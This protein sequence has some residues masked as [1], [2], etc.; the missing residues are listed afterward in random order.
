MKRNE[1]S[2]ILVNIYSMYRCGLV[3]EGREN[4]R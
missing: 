2:K 4:I 3:G 1:E